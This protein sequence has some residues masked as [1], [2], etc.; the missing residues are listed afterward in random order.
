VSLV[1]F[2]AVALGVLIVVFILSKGLVMAVALGKVTLPGVLVVVVVL[3][4]LVVILPL[5]SLIILVVVVAPAI[6][7]VVLVIGIL[8]L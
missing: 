1:F 6:L 2:V 3:K 5:A 4:E 7:A 8:V